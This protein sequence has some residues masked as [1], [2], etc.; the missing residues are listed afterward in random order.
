MNSPG[1]LSFPES[2]L[3]FQGLPLIPPFVKGGNEK[4]NGPGRVFSFLNSRCGNFM[5]SVSELDGLIRG[6]GQRIFR[7]GRSRFWSWPAQR[8]SKERGYDVRFT[9]PA[10]HRR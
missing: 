5:L 2:L 9:H 7:T 3:H 10:R 1:P 6:N 8:I 4:L